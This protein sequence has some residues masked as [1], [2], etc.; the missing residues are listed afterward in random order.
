MPARRKYRKR[1]KSSK[2]FAKKVMAVVNKKQ[3]LKTKQSSGSDASLI[4]TSGFVQEMNETAVAQGLDDDERV[5]DNLNLKYIHFKAAV[6]SGS[7]NG[8]VRCFVIQDLENASPNGIGATL[9]LPNDFFPNQQVA[10]ARYQI[11][12]DR[13]VEIDAAN[14]PNYLFNIRIPASKLKIKKIHYDD[15]A[16]TLSGGG[17]VRLFMTTL[18][19]TASQ[20]TVDSNLKMAWYD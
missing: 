16:T 9:P 14:R 6:S 3:E 19:T 2:S 4:A 12:Y 20:M 10:N 18:N 1:R 8:L 13:T 5:G 17:N 15:G 11:L 7:A